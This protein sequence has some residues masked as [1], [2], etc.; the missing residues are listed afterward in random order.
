MNS[1]FTC[2]VCGQPLTRGATAYRCPANHCFDLAAA[3]YT[4][5]LPAGGKHAKLPGDSKEM[6]AAR[7]RFL[8]AGYYAPLADKLAAL[9]ISRTGPAPCILDA[10]CGEGYYTARIFDA[11]TGA[12]KSPQVAGIDISKSCL[13]WAAKRE[14]GI[15]FAVASSYHLPIASGSID[16]LINCF[17]PLCL[18]E[19]S[20]ALKPG[21]RFLYVV[22]G[23]KHLWELKQVLYETP[24][25]NEEKRSDYAGFQ[26]E[27]VESVD[28]RI[29]LPS[30]DAVF[31]LFQMTP[32]FWKTPK[33]GSARLAA[34]DSLDTTISF[35]VHV[36]RKTGSA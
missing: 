31:S 25:Q 9:C 27:T 23:A 34:L 15:E 16:L 28:A 8:S 30:Q 10:G 3:G 35:Q 18:E 24:Y 1:L 11:L 12:G 36:F 5:L 4:Y 2:P 14:K 17:S 7:N 26:Y 32:Y 13:R 20:R 21:G 6:A 22:P 33:A 29:H 19:F